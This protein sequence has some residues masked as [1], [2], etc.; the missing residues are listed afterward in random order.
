LIDKW[1]LFNEIVLIKFNKKG[2]LYFFKTT[3]MI[4]G[5]LEIADIIFPEKMYWK[6]AKKACTSLGEGWRLPTKDELNFLFENK[7]EIGG[8]T[9]NYYWSSTE[10]KGVYSSW[11]QL[12][13]D[14]GVQFNSYVKGFKYNVRAVRD[15]QEIS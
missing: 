1:V 11:I 13:D 15:V 7:A 8:F 5:N 14:F 10:T 6:E 12:F 3:L 2:L 4:I 9:E